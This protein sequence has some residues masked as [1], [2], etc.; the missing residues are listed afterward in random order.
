MGPA[1]PAESSAARVSGTASAAQPIRCAGP[2]RRLCEWDQ[3]RTKC[4]E[5]TVD[6]A[7]VSR[8]QKSLVAVGGPRVRLNHSDGSVVMPLL[9]DQPH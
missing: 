6:G 5:I 8:Y 4:T 2:R 7:A 3:T 9:G 1:P